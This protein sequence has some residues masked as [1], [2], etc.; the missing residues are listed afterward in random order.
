MAVS[1]NGAS[2]VHVFRENM[3][4]PIVFESIDNL[5]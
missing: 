5:T 1:V 3:D 2:T 4:Q